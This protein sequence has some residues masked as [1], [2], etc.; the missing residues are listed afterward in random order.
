LRDAVSKRKNQ[1]DGFWYLEWEQYFKEEYYTTA[2]DDLTPLIIWHELEDT[3][4]KYNEAKG[5]YD[6]LKKNRLARLFT[7]WADENGVKTSNSIS[8]HAIGRLSGLVGTDI[9]WDNKC[10]DEYIS[11]ENT[12]DGLLDINTKTLLPHTATY[13]SKKQVPR[14]YLAHIKDAPAKLTKLYSATPDS[15]RLHRFM[16]ALVHKILDDEMFLMC[17][18]K[19]GSGKSTFL[20]LVGGMYGQKQVSKTK[21]QK[22]GTSFGLARSYDKRANVVPDLSSV[23]MGAETVSTLKMVT[24]ED[25]PIEV[26]IKGTPQF[27][28]PIQCLYLFGINQ[29]MKFVKSVAEEVESIMRRGCLVHYPKAQPRDPAFKKALMDPTFLDEL[30][31]YYVNCEYEPIMDIP[32]DDWVDQTMEQWLLDADPVMRIL[33]EEYIFDDAYEG[34]DPKTFMPL[35]VQ[36]PCVTVVEHVRTILQSENFNPPEDLQADV[37]Q[38]FKS[39]KVLKNNKRG[40]HSAYIKVRIFPKDE[41]SETTATESAPEQIDSVCT[42]VRPIKPHSAP[43]FTHFNDLDT[44]GDTPHRDIL[45]IILTKIRELAKE[46][47]EPFT[48]EDIYESLVSVPEISEAV[49]KPALDSWYK[50][51]LLYCLSNGMY[52][53][54]SKPKKRKG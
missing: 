22:L 3:W 18:G 24:G 17:Y 54:S 46:S 8:N 27:E 51:G 45:N 49:I 44:S 15:L 16:V 39:M 5:V 41:T 40:Q 33:Q 21:L 12:V 37:T 43:T 13:L 19:R 25:G 35:Y 32:L 34:H 7:N 23:P 53:L 42:K 4:Y 38:A 20:Q 30:F 48:W 36:I 1:E 2:P 52:K 10:L 6:E 9:I 14:H 26:N 29:L 50:D 47:P 28:W 11:I 31:S